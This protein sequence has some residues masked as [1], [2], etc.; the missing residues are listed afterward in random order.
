MNIS[1]KICYKIENTY[2][3]DLLLNILNNNDEMF[4]NIYNVI[5]KIN[6]K[7]IY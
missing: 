2:I 1:E 3:I 4:N 7:Y 6:H 5:I